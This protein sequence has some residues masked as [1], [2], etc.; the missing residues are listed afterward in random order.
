MYCSVKFLLTP[1]IT[2]GKLPVVMND[3]MKDRLT[4]ATL[5]AIEERKGVQGLSLRGIAKEAGCSHVNVYH[6][7]PRGLAD[8]LWS[9]FTIGLESFTLACLERTS[10]RRELENMGEAM[11]RAIAE[12]ATNHEGIYRLLWFEALE[13]K[14]DDEAKAAIERSKAS[15]REYSDG[16][17][18]E[19][20]EEMDILFAYLQGE[21]ALMINGRSGPDTS[22]VSDKIAA[23]AG[24]MWNN[25][26]LGSSARPPAS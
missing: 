7:A 18:N 1:F 12:F 6:Y 10:H 5:R 26:M 24:R 20:T 13:G 11:A 22:V 4:V 19:F 3:T 23:R 15:F 2:T 14:P 17:V 21:V 25:L 16:S 8:L 9:A